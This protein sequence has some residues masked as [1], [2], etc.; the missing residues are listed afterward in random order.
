M[1]SDQKKLLNWYQENKRDLP[2]RNITDP[3]QIWI[4]EVMLQQT[5]VKAVIPYY[6][7]FLKM[8]PNVKALAQGSIKEV[9]TYWAGLG[10]YSRADNLHKASKKF[11]ETGFP[12]TH[13]E[14]LDYPG[15]GPYTSRA[16]SSFAFKDSVGV[17]DGNVIRFLCRKEGLSIPWWEN[18]S[19]VILQKHA[20]DWVSGVD[21]SV[22]NQALIEIGATLCTPKSPAC[23]LCPLRSNCASYSKN[24]QDKIP[25]KKARKKLEIWAWEPDI[26][27]QN[28]K[29]GFI[30][31]N[32][33]SFLKGKMIFPGRVKKLKTAPKDYKFKH[34]ITHHEIYVKLKIK[35]GSGGGKLKWISKTQIIKVNPASLIQKTLK[36][37]A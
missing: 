5:T 9:Y 30:K 36:H 34:N 25:L 28:G 13:V 22:M 20:D 19:R 14:L 33:A 12:K 16:V 17:L 10:Y 26:Y 29:I 11:S 35:R 18:S 7:K 31:N 23:L 15:F 21:S 27:I 2:W 37:L 4:S 6:E 24:L 32:Y 8:F 3:Y 1:T